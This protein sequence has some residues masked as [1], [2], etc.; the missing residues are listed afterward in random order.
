MDEIKL[1][2]E[3]I[4][5]SNTPLYNNPGEDYHFAF[6]ESLGDACHHCNEE[7]NQGIYIKR[8]YYIKEQDI[9]YNEVKQ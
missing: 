2:E 8:Q 5:C 1:L 9:L 7:G 3:V 4:E 6:E